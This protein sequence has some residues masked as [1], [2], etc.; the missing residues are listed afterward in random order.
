M[1][2]ITA[3][4]KDIVQV[5]SPLHKICM[6]G[7]EEAGDTQA[8]G[9]LEPRGVPREPLFFTYRLENMISAPRSSLIYHCPK[10]EC[11]SQKLTTCYLNLNLPDHSTS[12]RKVFQIGQA[13]L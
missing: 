1:R 6:N 4:E 11:L 9:V 7:S 2:R 10:L 3:K 12:S 8:E 13:H 5:S